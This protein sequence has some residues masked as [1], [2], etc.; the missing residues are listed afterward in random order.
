MNPFVPSRSLFLGL[1]DRHHGLD[2]YYIEN[3]QQFYLENPEAAQSIMV[4]CDKLQKTI[5]NSTYDIYHNTFGPGTLLLWYANTKLIGFVSVSV[6]LDSDNLFL[7]YSDV[8]FH[9]LYRNIKL[10]STSAQFLNLRF[11]DTAQKT[12]TMILNLVVSGNF[13]LFKVFYSSGYFELLDFQK[14]PSLKAAADSMLKRDFPHQKFCKNGIIKHAWKHQPLYRK[15]DV[16][17][18]H[19]V[20]KSPYCFPAD[21]DLGQGDV[22]F[23]LFAW[24]G[25]QNENQLTAFDSRFSLFQEDRHANIQ[26]NAV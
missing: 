13:G 16:W 14:I 21:V 3:A 26:K 20:S 2:M 7:Y 17:P 25:H 5:W 11:L 18:A 9:P 8:M 1:R 10:F 22:L 4:Q 19:L 15:E 24:R 12:G 6:H 23:R